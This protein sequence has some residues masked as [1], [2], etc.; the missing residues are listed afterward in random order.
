MDKIVKLLQI[1]FDVTIFFL[2]LTLLYTMSFK[3]TSLTE[4]S[5]DIIAEDNMLYEAYLMKEEYNVSRTELIT[6]LLEEIEYD[7]EVVD[8]I[9]SYTIV[10]EEYSPSDIGLYDFRSKKFKKSYVYSI[11]G[12]I[13]KIRYQHLSE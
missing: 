7:I 12:T 5:A 13:A 1:A 2:A 9:Q 10:A 4:V 8:L 6:L 11:N 3:F